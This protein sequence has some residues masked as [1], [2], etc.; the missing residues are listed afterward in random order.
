MK[1][2]TNDIDSNTEISDN[3][4]DDDY[5]G[6]TVKHLMK[7]RKLN[8]IH[9]VKDMEKTVTVRIDDVD[10][11]VEPDSGADVNVM[12]DNQFAKFQRKTM[13]NPV[14]EKTR[15]KLSTL[16]S[17]LPIKGEFNTII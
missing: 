13:G 10:M 11:K 9:G 7:I 8:V 16:Q 5:F 1:E 3:D 12:D 4:D 17:S 6:G 2:D 14:L 15:I